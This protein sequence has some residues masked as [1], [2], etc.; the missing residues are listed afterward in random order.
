[1]ILKFSFFL[2]L[3]CTLVAAEHL[4]SNYFVKNNFVMLSDLVSNPEP[5]KKIFDIDGTRH[6]KR[7]KEK[8]VLKILQESGY[9]NFSSKHSYIQF[10]K[11][12]P[13]NRDKLKKYLQ[14]FYKSKYTNITINS[15]S[16][17]P[18][19][20]IEKLPKLYKIGSNDNI[21]LENSGILF[22][23]T[24]DNKKIFFNYHIEAKIEVIVVTQT[25]RRGSE[26]SNIN[27]QKKSIILDKFR[28]TPLQNVQPHTLELKHRVKSDTI[29]TTRD[30]VGLYLIKRGSNINV[31]LIDAGIAISFAAEASQ[32]G[33]YG[34]TIMATKSNGKKIKVLVTGRNRAEMR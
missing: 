14:N 10:S 12:S 32:S 31:T 33:R 24:I 13:I 17:E 21:H 28:A 9:E 19:S 15:I 7:V 27:T 6:T 8:E 34:D 11:K 30:V 20:Y 26:L 23:K 5:D 4:Q 29:L 1:M 22:I 16:V 3:S 25:M 18:R 2:L